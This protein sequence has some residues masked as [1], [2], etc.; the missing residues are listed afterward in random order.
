[1][2]QYLKAKE[3]LFH[4]EH[5]QGV[6]TLEPC[7]VKIIE[8]VQ[9]N[10]RVCIS[11]C[12]GI[13]K[14]F[15]LAKLVLWF[16]SSHVSSKVLTT[17]PTNRQVN[18]LL[19]SEIRKGFKHANMHLGGEILET[20]NWKIAED[21]FAIGY[22]PDKGP[23]GA[24]DGSSSSSS[25]QGFHAKDMLIIIDEATGVPKSIWSQIE[26]MST[27]G[28]VKIVGI[29]NP[30]TKN[31]T[32]YEHFSSRIWKSLNLSC[33]DSPN[34]Q[35]NG[36]NNLNDL[37]EELSKLM[38]L[39]DDEMRAR[40]QSYKVKNKSLVTANWVMTMALPDGWGIDSIPF[41]TRVLGEWPE[42]ED[43]VFFPEHVVTKAHQRREEPKPITK[44]YIGI[45]PARFG[46]DKSVITVIE[47]FTQVKRYEIVGKDTSFQAGKITQIV[48]DCQRVED[49]K[50][51]VDATGVG[52]GVLDQLKQNQAQGL[53]PESI[54]LIE[55]HFGETADEPLDDKI[56]QQKD[57]ERYYNK[58][59]KIIDLLAK[60][61]QDNLCLTDYEVYKNE[62]P[63]LLY[64]YDN[65]GRMKVE[66][67]DDYIKRTGKT[68][69][70]SAE[71]LAIANY[72]R[73]TK[74]LRR[75]LQPRITAL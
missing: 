41:K 35:M 45:D 67:K 14:T 9:Q 24:R 68:S 69:P 21:W 70:D 37:R 11:A 65:K 73:H 32:F 54:S 16:L 42:I 20:P 27:S 56:K 31:C 4:I 33:F 13:G 40:I 3:P 36:F 38:Q 59:A 2:N 30:T 22:S 57:K 72:G 66:N 17:A 39:P 8:A 7:H 60:D 26:S 10:N 6:K 44:R 48:R 58:K 28:N 49:E 51:L 29:G 61:I 47:N 52:G 75:K 62:L 5:F 50:I 43:D 34:L 25:F 53:I 12:H 64:S 15:T 63:G 55:I 74:G 71:S 1:M 18:S 46:T 23:E 19:W